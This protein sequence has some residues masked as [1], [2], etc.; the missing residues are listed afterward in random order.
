[1]SFLD[2]LTSLFGGGNKKIDEGLA[3][4]KNIFNYGLDT[5]K[6]LQKTSTDTTNEG[7]G[8]LDQVKKFFTDIM[9]N[10]SSQFAAMAPEVNST[11]NQSDAARTVAAN[12]GTSR[13]GGT[14][15]SSANSEAAR[16][17]AIDDALLGARPQAAQGAAEIGKTQ[18]TIGMDQLSAALKSIGLSDEAIAQYTQGAEKEKEMN[19]AGIGNLLKLASNVAGGVDSFTKL[20]SSKKP[21][22]GSSGLPNMG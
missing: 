3:G 21:S 2:S 19:M 18:A 15:A 1:M 7:M 8:T 4:E 10:R 9:G 20:L 16:M 14:A 22:T 11:N 6:A 13:G 17:K 12:M 5:G